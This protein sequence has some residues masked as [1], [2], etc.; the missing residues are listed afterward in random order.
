MKNMRNDLERYHKG[1]VYLLNNGQFICINS[2]DEMTKMNT[3]EKSRQVRF[4]K[5][6][7]HK[8]GDEFKSD[9][10]MVIENGNNAIT[11][12]VNE[13]VSCSIDEL[14]KLEAAYIGTINPDKLT[15]YNVIL[16]NYYDNL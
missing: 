14:K 9:Y 3:S 16:A 1:Q 6:H 5:G 13:T 15:R 10:A 2:V 4:S 11:F 8:K 12:E 7:P